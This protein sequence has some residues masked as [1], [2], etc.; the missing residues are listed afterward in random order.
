M[1][2][3]TMPNEP[4]RGQT[5][6]MSPIVRLSRFSKALSEEEHGKR[7]RY[8]TTRWTVYGVDATGA[9]RIYVEHASEEEHTAWQAS[10][11]LW[12]TAQSEMLRRLMANPSTR[13]VVIQVNLKAAIDQG[14]IETAKTLFDGLSEAA[15]ARLMTGHRDE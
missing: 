3:L 15:K 12:Q 11:P 10:D 7:S 13:D 8:E 5:D 4:A 6:P 9:E 2:E 1:Q 14:D